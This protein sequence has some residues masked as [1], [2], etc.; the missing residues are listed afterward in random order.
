MSNINTVSVTP[1]ECVSAETALVVID[2]IMK[3]Y[4]VSDVKG[5]LTDVDPIYK[6]EVTFWNYRWQ[7]EMKVSEGKLWIKNG[8]ISWSEYMAEELPEEWTK[9]FCDTLDPNTGHIVRA[10]GKVG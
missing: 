10:S 1:L 4:K 6:E 3:G 2:L 8:H 9:Q 5:D 7:K